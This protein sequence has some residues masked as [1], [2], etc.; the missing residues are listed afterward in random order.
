MQR[1]P[2]SGFIFSAS[3]LMHFLGCRHCV[4]LDLKSL[5][6]NLV[7]DEASA[8][9]VL[10]CEKGLAH[11]RS[12]LQQ[13]RASGKSVAEI[14]SELKREERFDLTPEV[15]RSGPDVIYQAA[16]QLGSWAGYA[17]FLIRVDT[18]SLLGNFSYEVLDT[19]L[20]RHAEPKH[21][22]QLGIYSDMLKHAQGI[23]P[24]YSHVVLGD[25]RRES[26]RTDHFSAYVRHAQRRL[27]AF[28][29]RPPVDSYPLPCQHCASC[30]WQ[31]N[32]GARWERDDHLSLVANIQTPQVSKLESHGIRTVESLVSSLAD[33]RISGL[34]PDVF[35]RL[36]SQAALQ[37]YKRRTGEDRCELIAPAPE[38]GLARMPQPDPGDLFF[39]ME[40]DPL[41]PEG[42]EYLFG[43]HYLH[44]GEHV[45]APFSGA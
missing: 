32:C 6:E 29:A 22:V 28:A 40:G 24:A 19:K 23:E 44:A 35:R 8:A 12:F 9:D 11:E 41:H 20:S 7:R 36:Q 3:D 21:V 13:L 33:S 4:F 39:D 1:S 10:L 2:E 45:F 27:E 37:H 14:S 25:G 30:H 15:L 43:L 18:P 17:D 42:L 26:F 16:L 38:K 31:Q 5:S 34:N